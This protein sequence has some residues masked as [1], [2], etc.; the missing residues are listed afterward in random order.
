MPRRP[1]DALFSSPGD[2]R[3]AKVDRTE[4]AFQKERN[5]IR[6]A[7]EEKTMRLRGLRLA[8]EATEREAAA[9]FA[10]ANPID[11]NAKSRARKKA[12][13]AKAV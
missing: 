2:N 5:R 8:K 9:A 6:A 1:A 13:V 4:S 11:P 10:A 12:V 7:N 3:A